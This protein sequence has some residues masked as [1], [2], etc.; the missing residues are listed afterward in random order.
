MTPLVSKIRVRETAISPFGFLLGGRRL[1]NH[2]VL[3]EKKKRALVMPPTLIGPVRN[4]SV[5]GV[6]R[7]ITPASTLE[8]LLQPQE[9]RGISISSNYVAGGSRTR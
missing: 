3:A 4:V 7:V 8:F 6:Y 1:R 9:R 2:C 5:L